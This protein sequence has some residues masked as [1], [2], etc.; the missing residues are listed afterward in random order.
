MKWYVRFHEDDED[1]DY[2][3]FHSQWAASQWAELVG[4]TFEI[5]EVGT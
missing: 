4:G 1:T 5:V 3:P 2:G